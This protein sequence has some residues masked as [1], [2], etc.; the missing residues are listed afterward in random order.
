MAT[1]ESRVTVIS[2]S[3]ELVEG[4][5]F[6]SV[7][8]STGRPTGS[9]RTVFVIRFLLFLF[10][11]LSPALA[12]ARTNSIQPELIAEGPATP[13]GEVEL[14]I[15]MH[16][17]PGWHGY[18]RNPGDAG[19][20]M[21]VE[22]QLPSGASIGPLRYP[23]P[24]RLTVSGLM[25]YVYDRDY[26][27]LA[28]LKVPTG[29]KL[30]LR[31]AAKA[32]WL[33]C[34]DKICVPEEG[35][36]SLTL[37]TKPG[38]DQRFNAWRQALP[39]PLASIGH[40]SL[41]GDKIAVAIPLPASVAVDLPYLFPITEGVASYEAK[42]S[43]RRDG[44]ILVAEL[45]R[46]GNAAPGEFSAV[47]ALG[48]GRGLELHA[49]PGPVPN[50]GQTL[51]SVSSSAILWAVLGAIAGGVLLNLMPCVFPI[52]AL[53]ALTLAKAGGDERPARRDALAYAAGA[54]V[55]TGA[56]GFALLLLR[57]GGSAAGWAFQLQDPRTILLLL[58]LAVAITLT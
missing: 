17:R 51:G 57:A 30:P 43:F 54:I 25:N 39:R 11:F 53:K 31:I 12:E 7:E 35:E 55:G 42:Q 56:L 34:T 4:L 28:R 47:L 19:L 32:H 45:V 24:S 52:L 10:A 44:D 8:D 36:F 2:V 14:A 40:F 21:S 26:A 58:M 48:A 33:A 15:L 49:V 13:G 20:P 50:G 23:V 38:S 41:S 18:W 29:A 27:L 3:P 22:W 9:A 6:L 16:T 5:S 1:T 37:N 46:S